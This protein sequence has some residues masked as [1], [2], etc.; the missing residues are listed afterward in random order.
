MELTPASARIFIAT[1]GRYILQ[2][3]AVM[4]IGM[5]KV[6]T[7]K[8]EDRILSGMRVLNVSPDARPGGV[9]RRRRNMRKAI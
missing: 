6:S 7:G 9:P 3:S 8:T 2:L 1:L 4:T 5:K